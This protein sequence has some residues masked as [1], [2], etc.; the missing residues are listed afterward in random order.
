M[1]KNGKIV[2]NPSRTPVSRISLPLYPLSNKKAER[3]HNAL[4]PLICWIPR[5]KTYVFALYF[6][7]GG[8]GRHAGLWPDMSASKTE[9]LISWRFPQYF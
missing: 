3:K 2:E 4:F 1:E 9:D 5:G 7:G 8:Q 6:P